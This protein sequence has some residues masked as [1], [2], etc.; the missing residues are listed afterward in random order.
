MSIIHEPGVE[1]ELQE[2]LGRVRQLLEAGSVEEA[3]TVA[4]EMA[5]RWPEAAIAQQAARVLAPP[6]Y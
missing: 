5:L 6:G 1:T 4:Q 2:A 3:R